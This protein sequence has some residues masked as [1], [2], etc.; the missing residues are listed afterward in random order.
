LFHEPTFHAPAFRELAFHELA[1]HEAASYEL[2]LPPLP[3]GGVPAN[4]GGANGDAAGAALT[5]FLSA[6]G[7]FFSRLLLIWPF[8]TSLSRSSEVQAI[9]PRALRLAGEPIEIRKH[10]CNKRLPAPIF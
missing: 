4:R 10:G 7:F 2:A 3:R 9:R 5:L 6:F 8:A 1:P